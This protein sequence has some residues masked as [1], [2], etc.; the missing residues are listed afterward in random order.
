MYQCVEA[1]WAEPKP[2]NISS[3]VVCITWQHVAGGSGSS[4]ARVHGTLTRHSLTQ[5]LL[6]GFK[7]M[8]KVAAMKARVANLA[9]ALV[10]LSRFG[11]SGELFCV[12]SKGG[13][14]ISV[15]T[16]RDSTQSLG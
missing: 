11:S 8:T 12:R 5:P 6:Q 3:M 1:R 2:Q 10:W 14:Y 9:T 7:Q 15:W 13:T 16:A 4:G